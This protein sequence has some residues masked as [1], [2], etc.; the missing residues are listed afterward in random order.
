MGGYRL[1]KGLIL[2]LGKSCLLGCSA[3]N[4]IT[5]KSAAGVSVEGLG[6]LTAGE[7]KHRTVA[8]LQM[9]LLGGW[10]G[11]DQSWTIL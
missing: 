7:P 10:E 4:K 2:T 8:L 6:L 3:E 1:T 5:A 11:I 9:L